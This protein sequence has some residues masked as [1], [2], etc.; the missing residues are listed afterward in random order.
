MAFSRVAVTGVGVVSALGVGAER[1]FESLVAGVSGV[2]AVALFDPLDARSRLAAEVVG[3]DVSHVAPAGARG[4]SR[5]DAMALLAAD[6]AL[7]ASGAGPK[8]LGVCLGGT[9][10]GMFETEAELMGGSLERV[11]PERARRLLD[12]PLDRVAERVAGVLGAVRHA[13]V[14]AACASGAIAVVR[15]V[16]WLER[17]LVD[18]VLAGGA[19]GLCRLTFFGFDALGALDPEPCRPFDR[20]RRGLSLGEGAGFLAL[21]REEA[22]LERGARILAFVS[23]AA[24]GAEAHHITH[25]EPS[26]VRATEL[27][28][29]AMAS[30]GLRPADVDYVNAH[31]TGTPQNDAMEALALHG[32]LG[33]EARRILCSSCKGQL[34]H[35]LGAAG[36]IEACVTALALERGIAPPTGGLADPED[37]SLAH[38]LARGREASLRAALSCSFGF[39]GT[40]TVL[41]L[42][43]A[44]QASRAAAPEPVARAVV[45]GVAVAG[46]FGE[47]AGRAAAA[48]ALAEPGPPPPALP[49]PIERLSAE[50]SR[51]FDRGAA[52]LT[53]VAEL[54]LAD[55]GTAA[56]GSGLVGGAAFGSVTRSVEF[57]LRA[58][59]RGV[60]RAN[61]AEFPHLVGS[62]ATGNASIY[63]G[64]TGPVLAVAAGEGSAESALEAA[65]DLSLVSG[66][67]SLLAGSAE[68]LDAIVAAVRPP[69]AREGTTPTRSEGAGLVLVETLER[70][71]LRGATPLAALDAPLM[72][73]A[74]YPV[75]RVLAPPR[76][77][78][79]ALLL[80][81]SLSAEHRAALGS[82]RWGKGE[83][84]SLLDVVGFFEGLSGV[85]LA[86]AAAVVADG[87]ADEVLACTS[88]GEALYLTRFDRIGGAP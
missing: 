24:V 33:A 22:A 65:L 71:L 51:R 78:A 20:G 1:T 59:S 48:L 14:C 44:D 34:G 50:R 3:L 58:L 37:A 45:T 56:A 73:S 88:V 62:G 39:G 27:V 13:T 6:E 17:G 11:E 28:A 40:G 9:T 72:L 75:D 57:V 12:H 36:A 87:G 19:D 47:L 32:A 77:A 8:R 15:A 41:A 52:W 16:A 83:S 30:A 66:C 81:G 86:V 63:L 79:R 67:Q 29:E 10:G 35:T 69:V 31:G 26:A 85:V 21:E 68:G 25:P 4:W 80:R 54:C 53:R 43:R 74:P 23:G 60:R 18:R 2:R 70:A 46:A 55:A 84:R 5:T 61:P 76:N 64:L 42:E 82:S 38:V 7:R 49:S